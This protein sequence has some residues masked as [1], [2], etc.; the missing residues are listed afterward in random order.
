MV[1]VSQSLRLDDLAVC[2]HASWKLFSPSCLA[3]MAL[4]GSFL[5]L[6]SAFVNA[7]M[8]S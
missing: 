8:A 7:V 6:K 5:C 4:T 1:D 3:V 2:D